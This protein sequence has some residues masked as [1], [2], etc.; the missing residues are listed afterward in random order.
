[1]NP[2]PLHIESALISDIGRKRKQNQDSAA[3][4]PALGFFLVADGMGGHQ[5]G[6]TA[7][8]LCVESFCQKIR[9][10]P[11][12]SSDEEAL[13]AGL[14]EANR[15]ILRQSLENRELHGMGTT[16]TALK[17]TDSRATLLQVGDSR[18]YFW[19]DAG[20]WQITRDHSL[21]QEKLRA[22]LI[23]REQ[24]KTDFNKNVITRSVGFESPIRGDCFKLDLQ[25][26]DGFL[27]CSDGLTGPLEDP[28]I[29][30]ILQ[31]SRNRGE[32]L[33]RAAELL[34]E[35]ANGR[36]G[37]DNITVILVKVRKN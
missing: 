30:G 26:G 22:G 25:P 7:S 19:N 13:V 32:T 9:E 36:G 27:L 2:S 21:V 17:I 1:M 18:G 8:Q 29:W 23:T 15:E 33:S 4:L 37:D 6:E 3:A 28:E 20:L 14:E 12:A 35:S 34:V 11:A 31:D 24:V 5:G 10:S 16:A